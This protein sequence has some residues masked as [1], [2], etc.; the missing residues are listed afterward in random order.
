MQLIEQTLR[1]ARV[2]P[3]VAGVADVEVSSV[4][5]FQG[6]EKELILFSAVRSNA[7]K[8]LGFLTDFR[9]LNV[10]LTRARRGLVVVG[11]P[12]TLAADATW[13]AYLQWLE[14]RGCVV[15]GPLSE[16]ELPR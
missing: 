12:E 3:G 11:D 1:V 4:D 16:L 10:A 2:P 13:R 15:D 9:R 14:K 6:R 5:G 8:Q 7:A